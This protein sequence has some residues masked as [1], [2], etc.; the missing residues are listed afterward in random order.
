MTTEL[1]EIMQKDI[2]RC[3]DAQSSN[4][5]TR[6]LYQALQNIMEYLKVLK[7]TYQPLERQL[8]EVESL[9]IDQS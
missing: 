1:L 2:K 9:T 3:E 5:G 7:R 8:L 6:R 4:E